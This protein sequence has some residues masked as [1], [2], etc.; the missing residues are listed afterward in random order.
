MARDH[1][2]FVSFE[3]V[4]ASWYAAITGFTARFSYVVAAIIASHAC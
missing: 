2:V 4:T 3:L 1:L